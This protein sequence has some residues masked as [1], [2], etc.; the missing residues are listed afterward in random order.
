MEGPNKTNKTNVFG[1]LQVR[2]PRDS[3]NVGFIGFIGTFHGFELLNPQNIGTSHG[4]EP[5]GCE[6]HERSPCFGAWKLKTLGPLMVLSLWDA[7]TM[8]GPNVLG[9]GSSKHWDLSWF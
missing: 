9:H 6:N 8:R 1:S 7:K 2:T 4:F 5:L 3:E